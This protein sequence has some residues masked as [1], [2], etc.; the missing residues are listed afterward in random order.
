MLNVIVYTKT[1]IFSDLTHWLIDSWLIDSFDSLIV[2]TLPFLAWSVGGQFNL[3]SFCPNSAR[4]LGSPYVFF[5]KWERQSVTFRGPY[6]HHWH[7]KL[8]ANLISRVQFVPLANRVFKNSFSTQ[9]P[10]GVPNK[11]EALHSQSD[12]KNFFLR[13]TKKHYITY[14]LQHCHSSSAELVKSLTLV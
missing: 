11:K 4:I 5:T 12:R 10:Y 7:N 1:F 14:I 13:K 6:F 2:Y 9:K 3:R 8:T